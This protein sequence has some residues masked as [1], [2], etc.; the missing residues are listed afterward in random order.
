MTPKQKKKASVS[1]SRGSPASDLAFAIHDNRIVP[2]RILEANKMGWV[3]CIGEGN[4]SFSLR[5]SLLLPVDYF[6][7]FVCPRFD[8]LPDRPPQKP[9]TPPGATPLNAAAASATPHTPHRRLTLE[10]GPEV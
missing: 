9:T 7:T 4:V 10:M 8:R 1:S 5:N 6:E 3:D 2:V